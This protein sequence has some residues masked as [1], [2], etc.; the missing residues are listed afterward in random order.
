[1]TPYD[2]LNAILLYGVLGLVGQGTRAVVGLKNNRAS[3]T[4]TPS[5]QSVFSFAYF[6]ISLMIGFIAGV[7]YGLSTSFSAAATLDP[8]TLITIA[9]FGYLGADFVENAASIFIPAAPPAPT[10]APA[11]IP[12]PA[13]SPSPSLASAALP[14]SAVESKVA[15]LPSP[16]AHLTAALGIV[17]PHV[18]TSVWS[19]ALIA[20]FARYDLSNARR[21]AAAIGQF[22]V[23]AGAGFQEVVENL[24]YTHA[25]RLHAVF[26][27]AFPSI[28]DAEPYVGHPEKIGNRVYANRLGNGDVA[29]G[30]GFRFRGRGLIQ[31]TG[32]DEYAEFGSTLGK[33]ADEASAYC[34]TAE[35]AAMSGCW[36]LASRG[37]LPLA[38]T[39]QL[40]TI[41]KKVN[42]TAMLGNAERIAYAEAM[43]KALGG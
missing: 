37:C 13:P 40:S 27:H 6:G 15:A 36:Y 24:N 10:A 19:P 23:E 5:A 42:G 4:T 29:S 21:I 18:K 1:M 26:P 32:R 25:E 34:E 17:L 7:L 43:R 14:I 39:W 41:T 28:A 9:G 12:A 2:A 38:D 22:A 16:A 20:A 30:D 31:L 35:G 8:K 11:P 33:T 3:G